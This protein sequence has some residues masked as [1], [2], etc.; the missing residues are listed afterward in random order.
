MIS[1]ENLFEF[2]VYFVGCYGYLDLNDVVIKQRKN[3]LI[4]MDS[5]YLELFYLR[6]DWWKLD[7]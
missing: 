1:F 5:E 4:I 7:W 3:L 2:L 6:L